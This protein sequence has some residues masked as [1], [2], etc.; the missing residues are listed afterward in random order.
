MGTFI[1]T[2]LGNEGSAG[3]ARMFAQQI[4]CDWTET[5]RRPI[6]QLP[7]NQRPVKGPD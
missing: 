7:Q 2:R 6:E 3:H 5:G 1:Q 4:Q